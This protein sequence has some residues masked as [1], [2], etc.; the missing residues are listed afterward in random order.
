MQNFDVARGRLLS[1]LTYVKRI[2]W[3]DWHLSKEP[4]TSTEKSVSD[5]RDGTRRS[6]KE[7]EERREGNVKYL[8][9]IINAIEKEGKLLGLTDSV[10]AEDFGNRPIPFDLSQMGEADFVEFEAMVIRVAAAKRGG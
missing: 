6:V 9:V 1:E 8:N 2:A 7:R 10:R 5:G 3:I 4:K